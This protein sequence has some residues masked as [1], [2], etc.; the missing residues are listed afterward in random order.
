MLVLHHEKTFYQFVNGLDNILDVILAKQ[1]DESF[2]K[3]MQVSSTVNRKQQGMHLLLGNGYFVTQ[4]GTSALHIEADSF[5]ENEYEHF[6][7]AYCPTIDEAAL[8]PQ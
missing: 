4:A 6:H 8:I 2:Q 5:S 1:D 7:Q 3:V